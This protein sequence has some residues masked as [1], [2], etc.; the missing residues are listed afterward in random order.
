MCLEIIWEMFVR[1]FCSWVC[2]PSNL[3]LDFPFCYCLA[4]TVAS[5]L[6]TKETR[7]SELHL[8]L[9]V[10]PSIVLHCLPSRVLLENAVHLATFEKVQTSRL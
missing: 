4:S 3:R 5:D 2:P 7:L 6:N 1:N 8:H 10:L 9:L